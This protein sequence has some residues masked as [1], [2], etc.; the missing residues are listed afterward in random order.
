MNQPACRSLTRYLSEIEKYPQLPNGEINKLFEV[1]KTDP[2]AR[3]KIIQSNLKLVVWQ[4]RKLANCGLPMADL[5]AEGNCGLMQ[6][7]EK[8]NPTMARF[9]TYAVFWIQQKM[10]RAIH[11]QVGGIREPEQIQLLRRKVN[12]FV[13]QYIERTGD[14]PHDED[15]AE[16]TGVSLSVIRRIQKGMLRETSLD[17]P[18]GESGKMLSETLG[19]T[20]HPTPHEEAQRNSLTDIVNQIL[21]ETLTAREQEIV[22]QRHGLGVEGKMTLEQVHLNFGVTRERVRQV[23]SNAMKKIREAL[24]SDAYRTLRAE[25]SRDYGLNTESL[26]RNA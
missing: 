3:D 26:L 12:T 8:Y 14:R 11:S 1:L 9:S 5:I 15:I 22:R 20:E 21:S 23:Q 10:R 7:I 13:E 18:I 17:A 6:A 16:A 2:G 25:L 19:D 24:Q 4:A